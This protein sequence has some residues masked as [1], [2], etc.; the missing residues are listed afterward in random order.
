[1]SDSVR[2]MRAFYTLE[3][4]TLWITFAEGYLC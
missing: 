1:A 3:E 4:E 2:E